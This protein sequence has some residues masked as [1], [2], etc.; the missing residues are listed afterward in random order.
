MTLAT[1]R[2]WGWARGWAHLS[3]H[4]PSRDCSNSFHKN[5]ELEYHRVACPIVNQLRMKHCPEAGT[6]LLPERGRGRWEGD[7]RELAMT[8]ADS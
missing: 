5:R 4:R 1:P 8:H 2:A 3:G 6:E 7:L